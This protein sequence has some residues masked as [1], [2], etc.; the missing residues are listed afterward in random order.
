MIDLYHWTT[1]NGHKIAMFLEETE[2]GYTPAVMPRASGRW[3]RNRALYRDNSEHPRSR[4]RVRRT[5]D[6]LTLSRRGVGTGRNWNVRCS[7]SAE[8]FVHDGG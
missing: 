1:P 4:R 3:G 5:S 8:L 6:P 2:L 7:R